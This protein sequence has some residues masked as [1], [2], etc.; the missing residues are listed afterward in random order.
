MITPMRS[1]RFWIMLAILFAANLLITQFL[2]S[3]SQ[4]PTVTISYHA[5]LAQVGANN[6]V[7][8][9]STA[10]AIHG[11]TKAPVADQ[12]TGP[13]STNFQTQR[14]AF[15]TADPDALLPQPH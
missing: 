7:S 9:T 1:A 14:P 4:P 5:F 3:A 8:V 15:A 12:T 11:V 6:A 2:T 10:E 13:K